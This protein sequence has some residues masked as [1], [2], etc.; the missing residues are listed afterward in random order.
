M[1]RI[2]LVQV[3]VPP[4]LIPARND[5]GLGL[6]LRLGLRCLEGIH[7]HL[8]V[9]AVGGGARA[10]PLPQAAHRAVH[11]AAD[12]PA[13][14]AD[15]ADRGRAPGGAARVRVAGGPGGELRAAGAVDG[16]LRAAGRAVVAA[17]GEDE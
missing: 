16:D 15:R 14:A 8:H 13:H 2:A 7:L 12:E 10:H 1:E 5:C 17:A 9:H 6:R 11:R 3:V 4:R